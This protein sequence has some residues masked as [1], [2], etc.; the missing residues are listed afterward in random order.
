MTLICRAYASLS[1]AVHRQGLLLTLVSVT[2]WTLPHQPTFEAL[3]KGTVRRPGSDIV[4]HSLRACD[5]AFSM[6][7]CLLSVLIH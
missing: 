3:K 2:D 6:A 7:F 5:G 4:L 1:A